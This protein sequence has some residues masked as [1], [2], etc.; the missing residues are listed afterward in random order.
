[1][2]N[3]S[4]VRFPTAGTYEIDPARSSIEFAT[5]AIF[6]MSRVKGSFALAGGR[7]VV[8]EGTDKSSLEAKALATSFKTATKKR[9]H[10]VKSADFLDAEKYPEI[11][12]QSSAVLQRHGDWI[13]RGEIT[14][15][16]VS[17]PIDLV[18]VQTEDEGNSVT[19][20]ATGRVDRYAHGITKAKGMAARYVYLDIIARTTRVQ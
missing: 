6:G 8:S 10:H 2:L 19:W 20:R 13:V 11:R 3:E 1:M 16:G 9:D 4:K 15:R 18:V 7:V 14:A 5:R 17:A 12:F